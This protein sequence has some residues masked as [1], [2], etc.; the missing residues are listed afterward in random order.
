MAGSCSSLVPLNLFFMLLCFYLGA[1]TADNDTPVQIGGTFAQGLPHRRESILSHFIGVPSASVRTNW[2]GATRPFLGRLTAAQPTGSSS[3]SF[4][5][6][7]SPSASEALASRRALSYQQHG[8]NLLRRFL[9]ETA[10]AHW[11]AAATAATKPGRWAETGPANGM[12]AAVLDDSIEVD[13]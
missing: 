13:W 7:A 12:N 9:A 2:H 1:A 5:H 8:T 11:Q 6:L 10:S 3:S 4:S